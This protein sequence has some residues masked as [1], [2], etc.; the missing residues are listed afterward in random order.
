MSDPTTILG[1]ES[2]DDEP[3]PKDPLQLE[4]LKKLSLASPEIPHRAMVKEEDAGPAPKISAQDKMMILFLWARSNLPATQFAPLVGKTDSTI[5]AWRRKFLDDGPAGLEDKPRGPK[6]GSRL[7]EHTKQA[8]LLMKEEFPDYGV[9]R[10]HDMLLR[11][12]GFA[13]SATA[14]GRVLRDAGYVSQKVPTKRHPDKKRRFE[15]AKPNQLWQ[16]DIFTFILKRQGT[17]LYLIAFMD[18][19]SRF[20]VSHGLHTSCSGPLVRE[21]FLTGVSKYGLPEEVLTD[22]G[23]QY[24]SWR[25]K[26]AFRKLLDLRGVKQIVAR[27]RHPQTLGK[28][29]RFWGTLWRE[30]LQTAVFADLT[31]ARERVS[32][33]VDFYNF[34]RTHQGIAGM[35]PADRFF[36]AAPEVRASL[37]KQVAENAAQIAK[38]GAQPKPFYMTGRVGDRPVS[39]HAEGE[40]MIL[41]HGDG[42]RQEVV[43]TPPEDSAPAAEPEAV[44]P[45]LDTVEEEREEAAP[46]AGEEE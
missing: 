16:T 29:E 41:L 39:L 40:R 1:A 32:H 13:A 38:N 21:I 34:Q 35:V 28:V 4:L 9:R 25:G 37:E 18:D 7:P 6:K 15:R 46:D 17:R 11:S 26:S 42:E 2:P 20:I 45:E 14:I 36:E 44:E 10:I 30:C 22:Q 23:P 24:Y 43:L 8:I 12:Q 31:E 27:A 3:S 5:R 33:F 19:N